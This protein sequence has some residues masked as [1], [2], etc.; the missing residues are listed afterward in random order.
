MTVYKGSCHCGAVTVELKT[1]TNPAE[2]EIREC[3]CSFCRAHGAVSA[4]DPNGQ[5][6]Y[7]EQAPGD[8]VRY[9]FGSKTCDFIICRHCGVYLGATMEDD[10][11]LGYSTT[12]IKN[13]EDRA[14]FSKQAKHPDYE[15]EPLE[16]RL[17]RRRR[18]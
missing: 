6:R 17:A 8:I 12:Q 14:L 11:S 4:S 9:Q 13:F 1:V 7:I 10:G 16:D 18:N 2:I 3:R 5:I 15:G